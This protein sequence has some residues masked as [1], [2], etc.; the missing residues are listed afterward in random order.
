[1]K[2]QSFMRKLGDFVLGK[3]FYIVL[4][5]CVATIGISGYY[6]IRTMTGGGGEAEPAAGNASVVLPDKETGTPPSGGGAASHQ[7]PDPKPSQTTDP[8]Q[9]TKPSPEP[10]RTQPDSSGQPDDPEPVKRPVQGEETKPPVAVVYT[11]PVKGSVLRDFSIETLA[12]D[13]TLGDW[14]THGGLDISAE[15][16]TQV[17]AMGAGTVTQVYEDGLMGTTVAIDHGNGLET[18]YCGLAGQPTVSVG[19]AV[20]TGSVIGAVGGSA[21]AESGMDSHL[22]LE[23][24]FQGD[25]VNPMDYLPEK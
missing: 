1:M 2:N 13:P 18:V 19:D 16:G 11:W 9:T 23:A 25:R 24:V 3:G 7:T 15:M 21:I 17:L 14:R 8:A 12:L 22:H 5:L 10:A 4:F 6:L 20:E